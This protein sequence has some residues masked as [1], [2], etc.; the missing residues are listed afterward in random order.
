ML[1]EFA[2]GPVWVWLF[3]NEIPSRWTL[4]GGSLVGVAVITRDWSNSAT[5]VDWLEVVRSV[6]CSVRLEALL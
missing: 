1:L 4:L 6:I 3:M 2:L 5:L